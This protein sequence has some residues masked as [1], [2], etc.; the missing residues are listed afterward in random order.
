[1]AKKDQ[2]LLV[3]LVCTVCKSQ[4]YLT[5]RNKINTTEK[6]ALNKYCPTCRKHQPHKETSKLD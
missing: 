5:G 2:R 6:L 4:N 1:M 3:A